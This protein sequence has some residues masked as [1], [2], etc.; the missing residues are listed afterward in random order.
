MFATYGHSSAAY[1]LELFV[2]FWLVCNTAAYC[3]D[4]N[5]FSGASFCF[6]FISNG[7]HQEKKA[8]AIEAFV[9]LLLAI[10]VYEKLESLHLGFSFEDV[11]KI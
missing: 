9:I 11:V 5:G 3:V 8:V 1:F 10:G 2:V 7:I 4:E 6:R